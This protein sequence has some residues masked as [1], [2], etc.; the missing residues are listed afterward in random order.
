M[1]GARGAFP[2]VRRYDAPVGGRGDEALRD[3]II[4]VVPRS[5][6]RLGLERILRARMGALIVLGDGPE[7]LEICT[8]GFH[9]DAEMTPPRLSELAKMDGA[10]VLDRTGARIAWANVHL[11]PDPSAPTNET[12]TRHRT[13]ERVARCVDVPVVAVS[14]EMGT[15][16]LYRNAARR[17]LQPTDVLISRSNHLLRTLERFKRRLDEESA[18]L[19]ASELEDVVAVRDVANVLQRA[20]MVL[21]VSEEIGDL[22]GELG[23]HGRMLRVQLDELAAG[24]VSERRLLLEDYFEPGQ[25]LEIARAIA[26]LNELSTDDLLDLGRV[27]DA[28]GFAGQQPSL[29]AP[30]SPH[31]LRFL[32]HLPQLSEETARGLV[33]HFGDLHGLVRAPVSALAEVAGM[34]EDEART[35]KNGIARLAETSILGRYL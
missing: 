23:E 31:G 22:L 7:V 26:R 12:G 34:S 30:L 17:Q 24:V 2:D 16:T 3:L 8:G 5:A 29:D 13:A 33:G 21:R 15:I 6:L 28:C 4:Q 25:E 35:V 1:S 9:I 11:V 10:I 18:S 20:E 19:G 14:E 32:Q 27:V